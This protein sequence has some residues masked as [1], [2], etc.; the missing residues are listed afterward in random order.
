LPTLSLFFGIA[1][2]IDT[3][4]VREGRLPPRAL[5]LVLEW[6][7]AH[8]AELRDNWQRAERHEPLLAIEP[9]Q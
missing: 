8:R 7:S 5:A 6:A 2:R 9:L 3:L 4:E 1:V